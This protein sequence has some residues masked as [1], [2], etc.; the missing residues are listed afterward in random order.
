LHPVTPDPTSGASVERLEFATPALAAPQ[1]PYPAAGRF[2]WRPL[3][4]VHRL[5]GLLA[6][7][8][9]W[10][11]DSVGPGPSDFTLEAGSPVLLTGH[12]GE[13]V[14]PVPRVLVKHDD[15]TAAADVPVQFTVSTGGGSVIQPETGTNSAGIHDDV[16]KRMRIAVMA[17]DGSAIPLA[18]CGDREGVGRVSALLWPR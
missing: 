18:L 15:G 11:G 7:A 8:N 9:C 16:F 13:A 2:A 10:G 1:R 14:A 5:A 4:A 6:L 12:A 3:R 17:M